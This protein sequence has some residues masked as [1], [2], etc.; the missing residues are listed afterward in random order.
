M[1]KITKKTQALRWLTDNFPA[2]FFKNKKL[3]KPVKIGIYHDL[4]EFY[5]KLA[6]KPFSK[7]VLQDALSY[8]SASPFY[9]KSQTN[10]AMRLDLFGNEVDS[11]TQ[12]QAD[13]AAQLHL[14]R[15]NLQASK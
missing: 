2:A 1:E 14:E 15:Y 6:I 4:L 12:K 11:V 7:K 13:Y 3:I 8:Y 5:D 9:L 10:G